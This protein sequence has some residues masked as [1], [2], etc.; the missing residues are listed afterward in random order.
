MTVVSAEIVL[1]ISTNE[2]RSIWDDFWKNNYYT[3]SN[4]TCD[5]EYIFE[6]KMVKLTMKVKVK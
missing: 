4:D 6:M 1:I 2:N 3:A 5:S